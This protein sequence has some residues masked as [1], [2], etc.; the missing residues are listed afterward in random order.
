MARFVDKVFR[1][2]GGLNEDEAPEALAEGELSV[3][4]NCY[5]RGSSMGTR[6][7]MLLEVTGQPYDEAITG[8]PAVTGIRDFHWGLDANRAMVVTAGSGIWKDHGTAVT[9]ALTV[10][11]GSDYRWTFAEHKDSLYAA[12]GKAADSIWKWTGTGNASAVTFQNDSGT[13]IDAKYIFQKWNYGFLAGMNGTAPEDNA[14]VARYSAL[15]DMDVW[16]VGNTIGGSS[17]IGGFSSYADEYLTGFGEFTDNH[18]DWLLVLSTRQIFNVVQTPDPYT[19]FYISGVI[20]NGCVGQSAFVNL[21]TD[22]GD[23]IYL[24]RRG[25]HSVRQSQAHGQASD[26]FLSWKIRK[27]FAT[28]NRTRLAF[29]TAA[30]W[31]SEGLVL[32]LVSSGSNGYQDMILC[33][34]LK[35]LP[36]VTA[37]NARWTLWRIAIP[38]SERATVITQGR[39]ADAIGGQPQVY[40]GTSAGKIARFSSS[41]FSD[42]TTAGAYP[43]RFRT[44]NDTFGMPGVTKGI[45]DIYLE[46]QPGGDYRPK[47]QT[48]FDF[49]RVS[50]PPHDLV[51]D[52][53]GGW[54]FDTAKIGLTPFHSAQETNRVRLYGTGS[55]DSIAHE[56]T[57]SGSNEPFWVPLFSAQVR[58]FGE[59]AG[60]L[61][62]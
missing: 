57:H 41:F 28:L 4:E 12:G 54:L 24:S 55:G 20:Q 6:P 10:S 14:M 1:F 17:A 61:A 46:I 36:E 9:G 16:P 3:A 53:G 7:G 62:E 26:A 18:G 37:D 22:S 32:F 38:G 27:T 23:A 52:P 49:G 35:G 60:D 33:L 19:P 56:F 31:P 39:E 47:F 45:G 8:T 40:V 30:Y 5:R 58:A 2:T 13:G 48:F 43:V 44:R 25:I 42:L 11:A 50:T 21:G 59:N 34:D 29:T 15:S 51:M